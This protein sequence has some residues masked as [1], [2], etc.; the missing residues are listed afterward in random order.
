MFSWIISRTKILD[1][2]FNNLEGK[3]NTKKSDEHDSNYI[4]DYAMR[5]RVVKEE[6]GT[7]TTTIITTI[8]PP[9]TP[10]P[11]VEYGAKF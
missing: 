6:N 7:E 5:A 10:K 3:E 1:L 4:M 2:F 11:P 8:L 9:T